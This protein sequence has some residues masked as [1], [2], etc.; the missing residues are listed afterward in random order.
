VL[1]RDVAYGQIPR[2]ARAERHERA[3]AWI[4]ALGRPDDHAEMLAH[5]YLEALALRRAAGQQPGAAL[6][7]RARAAARDAGDRALALASYGAARH[8][9]EAALEL[10][11]RDAEDRADLLL[12]YARSRVDDVELEDAVLTG[13]AEGFLRAG[14]VEDAAEAEARLGG[15]WLSRG[16]GSRARGHFER[17]RELVA[18]RGPSAA[19]AYVLHELARA[20]MMS[21]DNERAAAVGAE[22]LR[23]ADELGLDAARSRNL[24]TIGIAK[25]R[26]GDR[27]GLDDLGRAIEI[28][29]A[30]GSHEGVS[31]MANLHSVLSLLGELERAGEL[32]NRVLNEARRL[33]LT[34]YVRW[35]EAELVVRDYLSG[36]WT[37]AV[38]KASAFLA[39]SAAGSQHYMDAVC[40]LVRGAIRLAR[41][42]TADAL[43]DARRGA[44]LARPIQDPQ[45][46]NPAL[47]VLG[48]AEL[49][50]GNVETA[51][52][53]ADELRES[54]E[55]RGL[56]EL[57]EVVDAAWLFA[58][59]GRR[60]ELEA[61][62]RQS[63]L[64]TPW[65]EA[66]RRIAAGDAAGAA[67]IY[68]GIGS[69]PDEAYARLRAAE[70]FVGADDRASGDAQLRLARPVFAQLGATAWTVE[71]EAL[72]AA[73]A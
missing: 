40:L 4:D 43:A 24:N 57:F 26:M 7:E 13:A 72:L 5:H 64:Q 41:G 32:Q 47:A 22:S 15:V 35:Q 55:G 56:T 68:A 53:V 10:W 1:V 67:D 71:A 69:V 33:G 45:S 46:L 61:A 63:R 38:E 51:T 27:G 73:S 48:R 58:A 44:E 18:E 29:S 20:L 54:W 52:S 21:D 11:P 19:K 59:L 9:Y 62:L 3:A 36:G 49:D 66:A 16:D 65:H 31:A 14:R 39:F 23:L 6:V 50:A 37:E 28:G 8:F 25:V 34:A 42:E 30:A 17:A 70:A 12:S 2:A 60:G